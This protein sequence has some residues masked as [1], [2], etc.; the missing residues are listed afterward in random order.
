[1]EERPPD[2]GGLTTFRRLSSISPRSS[3]RRSSKSSSI[4]SFHSTRPSRRWPTWRPGA[5][6]AF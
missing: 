4:G 6:R 2:T 1:M 5:P 3:R